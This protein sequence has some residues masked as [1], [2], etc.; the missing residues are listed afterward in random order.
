VRLEEQAARADHL[1]LDPQAEAHAER[2]DPVGHAGDPVRQLAQVD[3]PV[4]ERGRVVVALAEPAV[5]EDEQLDAQLGRPRD[6]DE[7]V[8]VKSK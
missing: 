1:G 3:G 2:L 7:L 8:L 6:L 4:A 5:V